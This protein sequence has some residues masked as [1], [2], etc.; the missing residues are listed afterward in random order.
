MLEAVLG[1]DSQTLIN[2]QS[3]YNIDIVKRDTGFMSRLNEL[4][5]VAVLL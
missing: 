5:K 4:R 3:N 1:I 2:L